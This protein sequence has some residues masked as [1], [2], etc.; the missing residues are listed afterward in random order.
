[1]S[2]KHNGN[3]SGKPEPGPG[4]PGIGALS[5]DA[6]E[7]DRSLWEKS[8]LLSWIT[9]AGGHLSYLGGAD[10][11]RPAG[12]MAHLQSADVR[13]WP[14]VAKVF[15]G[16]KL[17]TL[18]SQRPV[19]A[20]ETTRGSDG[21][22]R[23]VLVIQFAF[24]VAGARYLAGVAI[25]VTRQ[26]LREDELA[27]LAMVDE[28]TGLYNRRGFLL[29][30]EHELRAARRRKTRLA[31]FFIDIDGLKQINDTR[32][33]A[34]G[35][36]YILETVAILR[37]EFRESDVIGRLGGD[38]FAV[39]ASDIRGGAAALKKRLSARLQRARPGGDDARLSAS[40][41]VADCAPAGA[42]LADLL[43]AAD[44]AMYRD[45]LGRARR[46]APPPQARARPRAGA[47]RMK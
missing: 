47:H 35:N 15:K 11:D 13:M 5:H 33:H 3:G 25:D 7:P 10:P 45:K 29:L 43:A 38:E 31:A 26:M 28:L 27:H 16:Q 37:K 32:G 41:G 9:D 14:V 8:P 46:A 36:Q 12:A 24:P 22:L 6:I 18:D 2:A 21:T 34:K 30:G 44:R 39:L 4:T 19:Q 1:M 23:H 20:L 42:T 17:A 40:I